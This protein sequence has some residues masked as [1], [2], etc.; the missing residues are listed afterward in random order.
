[1]PAVARSLIRPLLAALAS[2]MMLAA[3]VQPGETPRPASSAPERPSNVILLIGDGMGA[4][5]VKSY[6]AFAD[7]PATHVIEPLAFDAYHVGAVATDSI[8]LDC[9]E[10]ASAPCV[11]LPYGVTDS[12]SSA[13][14]YASGKDTV[15]G[16]LGQGPDGERY[17]TVLELAARRGKATGVVSTSQVTH[18]TPAAFVAHVSSRQAYAAIADQFVDNRVHGQPV[19]QVIL[20]GG[21]GDFRRADR[22]VA[23]ELVQ[24]GYTFV[25]NREDLLEAEGPRL[26]GL[27]APVGLPRH[28][29]RPASVP[30]LAEMTSKALEIL[31]DD[32]DG[33]F[34]IVEGSQIDWAA[35][36]NDIAGV[37]SEMEGFTEAAE[38]V[39]D[40][41]RT[42]GDTL[43]VITADHETGGLSL[44]RDGVYEWNPTDL[45]SLQ[46]TPAAIVAAFLTGE[47]TLDAVLSAHSELALTE[48]ERALLAAVPREELAAWQALNELLDQR[49]FTG[50][51]TAGHTGVDVPLYAAGPGSDAFHGLMENE[52]VGQALIQAVIQ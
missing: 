22:D 12:A 39:L 23:K 35:H 47:D 32:P 24:A 1:M 5:Q 15:I 2:A 25:V 34:L 8:V 16:M 52:A 4:A 6:R 28:W 27:F 7:D 13:T 50:W 21:K 41:V 45:R 19:A 30:S 37:V 43:V 42:R 44:G 11:R 40:F 38:R 17:D 31:D 51:T 3:C 20:G 10:D 49:T 18:A 36:G 9:R 46:A 33:F 48:Q 26:L 29:D 14:A